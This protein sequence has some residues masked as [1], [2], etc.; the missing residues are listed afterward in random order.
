VLDAIA[1]QRA[2]IIGIPQLFEHLPVGFL[3]FGAEC[4][5]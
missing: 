5:Y 2:E 1:L 4:V 3:A